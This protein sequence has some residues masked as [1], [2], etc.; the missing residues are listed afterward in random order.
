MRDQDVGRGLD[1][2][3]ARQRAGVG[4]R[5]DGDVVD[6]AERLQPGRALVH[7][8]GIGFFAGELGCIWKHSV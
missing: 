7:V 8:V 1:V 4:Q 3:I 2:I 6:L 5:D